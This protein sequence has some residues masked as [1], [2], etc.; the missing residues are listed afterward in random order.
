MA[1]V[2]HGD[3]GWYYETTT[4]GEYGPSTESQGP[5]AQ[6][7]PDG[8]PP[9]DYNAYYSPQGQY[10]GPQ[11]TSQPA[12]FAPSPA[13]APAQSAAPAETNQVGTAPPPSSETGGGLTTEQRSAQG[14]LQAD[15]AAAGFTGQDLGS[16]GDWA[17]NEYL[18]GVPESQIFLE[19]RQR[20]EY[21]RRFPAMAAL[22][23]KG[24]AISEAEY[25][26]YEK[27]AAQIFSYAGMAQFATPDYLNSLI[28]GEVSLNELNDRIQNGYKLVLQ[29]PQQVRDQFAQWFGPNSDA[30]LAGWF[31]DA[32]HT[33]PFIETAV[34]EAQAGGY[35][36][37]F[38]FDLTQEGA[39]LIGQVAPT[40]QQL[41]AGFQEAQ[42]YLP[43]TTETI[44]EKND[45]TAAD[46]ASVAFGVGEPFGVGG[47]P[48][49]EKFRKRLEERVAGVHG[50]GQAAQ[51]Q[52]GI[53]GAG[54][55][56]QGV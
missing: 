38:G 4:Q 36:K 26:N 11:Q 45:L 3:G 24:H 33:E 12:Q 41:I 16:L 21:Q 30:A 17:W 13:P 34:Q 40:A 37:F 50:G 1:W 42:K 49:A 43:L 47:E 44:F 48:P 10:V 53:V 7:S 14:Q 27:S 19:M 54:V 46:T 56:T 9:G 39:K 35:A 6:P 18:N 55:S 15:L 28:A 5:Y 32:S 51:T 22:A 31:L 8:G 23:S 20:P 52:Q 29:A 2:Q 25:V